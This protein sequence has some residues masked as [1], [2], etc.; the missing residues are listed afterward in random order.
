MTLIFNRLLEIVN[1]HARAKFRQ[2]KCSGS[3]VI[4]FIQMKLEM[5]LR[6]YCRCRF[7]GQ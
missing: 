6:Q 7:P 3:W 2:A 1:V 4:M 5:T